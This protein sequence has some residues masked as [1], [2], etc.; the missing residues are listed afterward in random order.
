MR[1]RKNNAT[2]ELHWR[3][4]FVVK[5]TKGDDLKTGWA[6]MEIMKHTFARSPEGDVHDNDTSQYKRRR[7]NRRRLPEEEPYVTH[8]INSIRHGDK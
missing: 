3:W 4:C 5:Q 2:V 6:T 8:S 1:R 7:K